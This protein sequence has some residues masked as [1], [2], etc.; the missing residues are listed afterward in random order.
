GNGTE[1]FS[2]DGGPATQAML[3]DPTGVAL[4][5]DGSIYIA[6]ESNNRV[7]KVTPDGKI[8]TIAGNGSPFFSGD[9]GPAIQ[10]GLA[11][12]ERLRV[13]P[14]ASIYLFALRAQRIR[15]ITTDGII[16]TVAGNGSAGFS[17]DGGPATSASLNAS[18]VSVAPDGGFYIAD[19]FNGRVRRV[20]LDGII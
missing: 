12:A 17:G 9:G 1:G 15:R 4:G 5:P 10:A 14:D 18:S 13:P 7:R 6:E 20:G 3:G 8:T 2:G 16:N 11:T 19:F